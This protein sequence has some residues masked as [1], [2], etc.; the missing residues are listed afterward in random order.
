MTPISVLKRSELYIKGP[1]GS[2]N[3]GLIWPKEII[4]FFDDDDVVHPDNFSAKRNFK[5]NGIK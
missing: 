1:S 5:S 2:R 3:Y 4:L